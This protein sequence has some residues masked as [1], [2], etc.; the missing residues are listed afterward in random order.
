MRGF[1]SI[2]VA[3]LF[4]GLCIVFTGFFVLQQMPSATG[5]DIHQDNAAQGGTALP[6]IQLRPEAMPVKG[7]TTADKVIAL[8]F[9]G[10]L[11][12]DGIDLI[13]RTLGIYGVQATFFISGPWA[14]AYPA[15]AM[16]L[17]AKG[18]ELGSQSYA[19]GSAR[20]DSLQGIKNDMERCAAQIRQVTGR[21]PGLYRPVVGPFSRLGLQAAS[22]LGFKAIG[23]E[24][25]AL[26]QANN[27]AD[28][29]VGRVMQSVKS[30]AIVR[31][32]VSGK[33]SADALTRVLPRLI[34]QGYR[35]VPVG[36]LLQQYGGKGIIY[37]T[38]S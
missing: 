21:Q 23:W 7:V 9:D 15:E 4:I 17:T 30:G 38:V 32:H 24:V 35:I 6:P 31:M 16:Q 27:N 13:V 1:L 3:M 8:S 11:G 29:I 37:D 33:A 28:M 34:T 5:E 25:D 20:S 36:E 12:A 19:Y 2:R 18:H 14:E 22:E 26:D 10:G